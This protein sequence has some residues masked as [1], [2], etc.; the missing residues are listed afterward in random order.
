M[1]PGAA[2]YIQSIKNTYLNMAE[3][4][5]KRIVV[6]G[7]EEGNIGGAIQKHLSKTHPICHGYSEGERN[8]GGHYSDWDKYN[9]FI[10]N[11]GYTK[12]DW[13]ENQTTRSIHEMINCN[14]G[15]TVHAVSDI[16]HQTLGSPEIK[17]IIFIGS[18]AYNHVLNGSAVYCASKA[19]LNMFAKCIA[20][21]LAPKGYRVFCVNP[22][23]VQDA[24][25]S[26][27][28]I[29]GLMDYRRLTREEAEAYWSAECPMGTFLN[30]R[31]IAT[32]VGDLLK[33]TSRYLAGNPIDLAGGGR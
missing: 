26:E 33:P 7:Y 4:T 10:F 9:T 25:M 20:Y 30:M 18:M 14:F 3:E 24:P 22:S 31:E 27:A 5:D 15:Y 16:V 21:E 32:I 23:N 11:N 17:T 19:G 8:L 12:L 13:I 1:K 29:R 2:K 6:L 28:T